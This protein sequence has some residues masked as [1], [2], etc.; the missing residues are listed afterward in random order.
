MKFYAHT[1]LYAWSKGYES[2]VVIDILTKITEHP[3]KN[4]KRN[5]HVAGQCFYSGIEEPC[6]EEQLGW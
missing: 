2:A 5:L 6:Q 4:G 3:P 1:K